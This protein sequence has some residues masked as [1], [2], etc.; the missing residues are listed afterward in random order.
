MSMPT[1]N[2]LVVPSEYDFEIDVVLTPHDKDTNLP[3]AQTPGKFYVNDNMD[4]TISIGVIFDLALNDN[5]FGDTKASDWGGTDHD[6]SKLVSSDD[7]DIASLGG[8]T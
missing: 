1:I 8:A 3:G 2:G 7:W 4:G 5:T 6:L